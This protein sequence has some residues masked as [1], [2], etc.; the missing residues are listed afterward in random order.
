MEGGASRPGGGA[1]GGRATQLPPIPPPWPRRLGDRWAP[2]RKGRDG[3]LPAGP[4][5]APGPQ[6]SDPAPIGPPDS[7]E[8]RARLDPGSSPTVSSGDAG[9]PGTWSAGRTQPSEPWAPAFSGAGGCARAPAP[10]PRSRPPGSALAASTASPPAPARSPGRWPRP[11]LLRPLR[12]VISGGGLYLGAMV[13][14]LL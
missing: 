5:G 14:L 12:L 11:P 8:G 4:R 9:T 2:Q 1:E 10:L 6:A 13:V 7:Q 3:G